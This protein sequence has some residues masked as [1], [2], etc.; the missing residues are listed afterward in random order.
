MKKMLQISCKS[1]IVRYNWVDFVYWSTYTCD[2][3]K[4]LSF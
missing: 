4:I 2:S 1:V 3:N